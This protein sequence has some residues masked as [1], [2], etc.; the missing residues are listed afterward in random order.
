MIYAL[1]KI[2]PCTANT[3]TL[4]YGVEVKF[5]NMEVEVDEKLEAKG[6]ETRIVFIAYVDTLW[7]PEKIKIKNPKR[8]SL[9]Y[10]PISRSYCS[11]ITEDS[12]IPEAQP[13]LRNAWKKPV[14]AE[15]NQALLNTWFNTWKGDSFCYE[16]HF[17]RHQALDP[18]GLYIAKRVYEDI[19]A[20]KYIPG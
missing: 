4:L 8:F 16:Y 20:L 10:A 7:G 15:E 1:D 12:V 14:T 9:L 18:G 19:R 17:W 6:L 5:Y 13:Y 2:A 11:S 3:D